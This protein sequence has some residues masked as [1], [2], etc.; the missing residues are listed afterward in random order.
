MPPPA[1]PRND[2]GA[3]RTATVREV[4]SGR[5]TGCWVERVER[6]R[7]HIRQNPGADLR[8]E[9]LARLAQASPYHFHRIFTALAGETP[10]ALCRRVRVER[11]AYL[12]ITM[13]GLRLSDVAVRAGFSEL[14]DLSRSFRRVYGCSPTDWRRTRPS[15]ITAAVPREVADRSSDTR[16]V[17]LP[18][19]R[20]LTVRVPGIIGIDD[21]TPGYD[22]L[23]ASARAAG[24]DLE[25]SQLVGMSWDHH[26]T[27]PADRVS[28]EFGLSVPDG[29]RAPPGLSI[30]TLPARRAVAV[31]CRGPMRSIAGAWDHLYHRWFAEHDAEPADLPAM[32]WFHRRPDQLR[33]RSWDLDCVI[34]L[35]R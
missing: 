32:K 5:G 10:G 3:A 22:L 33:W 27:T 11:A 8:L 17:E 12:M 18:A 30:T 6:V 26:D 23:L 24:A 35:E 13:P 16:I 31:R 29:V 25:R 28:Y 7:A 21:Q 15:P 14:S 34:A 9:S 2:S 4:E 20:L 1:R 19:V